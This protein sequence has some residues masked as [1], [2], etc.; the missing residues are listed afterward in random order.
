MLYAEHPSHPIE[1]MDLALVERGAVGEGHEED[2]GVWVELL[3]MLDALSHG[4]VVPLVAV[5]I[6]LRA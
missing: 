6:V 1:R 2:G 5:V 4:I 3:D